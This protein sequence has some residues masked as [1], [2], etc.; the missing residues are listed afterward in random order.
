MRI[1]ILCWYLCADSERTWRKG[2]V[3]KRY[4]CGGNVPKQKAILDTAQQR[5]YNAE[6]PSELYIMAAPGGSVLYQ[7]KGESF[8]LDDVT[9]IYALRW[10]FQ[11]KYNWAA[12]HIDEGYMA[13]EIG[14]V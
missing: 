7:G 6:D 12:S 8:L 2:H 3:E 14:N 11:E 5:M 1:R 10:F 9:T 4:P 13:L